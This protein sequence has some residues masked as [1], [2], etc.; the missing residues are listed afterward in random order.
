MKSGS[1]K[2]ISEKAGVIFKDDNDNGGALVSV[3]PEGNASSS[4]TATTNNLFSV[5]TSSKVQFCSRRSEVYS[6]NGMVACSQPLAAQAGV[7]I[8]RAGGN[9]VDAAIAVAAALN[10]T[11]PCSTGLGGDCFMLVH[12]PVTK[13][14]HCLNGSGR[15][16]QALT[17]DRVLA[18]C[19]NSEKR[20][21][22]NQDSDGNWTLDDVDPFHAHS[23]TVPGAAAGWCDAVDRW[24]SNIVS[25]QDILQPAI[26]LASEGFA[27]SPITAHWWKQGEKQL[28]LGPHGSELLLRGERAPQAGEVF[29][30]KHLA[31]VMSNLGKYGKESF[32]KGEPA[33]AIV[34]VVSKLGGLIT[35]E[36][37][38]THETTF[39]QAIST[40]YNGVSLVECPPNGQGIIAL[41]ATNYLKCILLHPR[42]NATSTAGISHNSAEYLHIIIEALRMAF[43]DGRTFVCDPRYTNVST[44]QLLSLEYA[45]KRVATFFNPVKANEN[46]K[47]GSPVMSCDTVSFQ[48]CDKDGLAVSMVNSN[49]QGFGSGLVPK[50]CGF[51]LQNRGA[52]FSLVAGHA[53]AVAGG[54]RPYH[55][56]L[57]AL[58][59]N[60]QSRKL[61]ASFTVMGGFMQPQGHLQMLLNMVD[62]K[63]SPQVRPRDLSLSCVL[64]RVVM[65]VCR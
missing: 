14:V 10:V 11:E 8:L 47:A 12:D 29:Q 15:A 17:L 31:T 56:I 42:Y 28:R 52:N 53:N 33:K 27:V 7:D 51:S 34:D 61:V 57:P 26:N 62:H 32:Y 39:P 38:A 37:I 50:G 46:V 44:S 40:S 59:V 45:K 13:K 41:L 4:S 20:A 49:Y 18:D 64:C 25:M 24:G 35:E 54:K 55:T 30:N 60:S 63:L 22:V 6:L 2:I 16:P 5:S 21:K 3:N 19:T 65:Y 9:A 36:D 48:V 23:V 1:S 43:A 58:L